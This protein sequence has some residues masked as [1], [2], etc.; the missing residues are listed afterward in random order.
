MPSLPR[1]NDSEPRKTD[2]ELHLVWAG[3]APVGLHA[4]LLP[5]DEIARHTV[6]WVSPLCL[7][8]CADKASLCSFLGMLSCVIWA[9]VLSTALK[10]FKCGFVGVCLPY[11]C[12]V[13]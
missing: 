13:S 3:Y 5:G 11:P 10:A 8:A 4:L 6:K 9:L 7:L 2:A 1:S 12:E